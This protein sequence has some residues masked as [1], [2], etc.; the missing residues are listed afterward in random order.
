MRKWWWVFLF[1]TLAA[2][3]NLHFL[4]ARKQSLAFLNK[5]LMKMQEENLI[6]IQTREDLKERIQSQS[7][8]AW[9]EMVLMRDLGVVPEGFLKVHFKK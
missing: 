6:A 1:C 3:V 2:G 8:P 7:D 5:R 9:I 4:K